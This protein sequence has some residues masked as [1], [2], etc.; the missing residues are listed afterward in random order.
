M[1]AIVNSAAFGWLFAF[2]VFGSVAVYAYWVALSIHTTG[3]A[4][5]KI[6]L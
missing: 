3:S 4:L 6:F 1:K 2:S 5:I